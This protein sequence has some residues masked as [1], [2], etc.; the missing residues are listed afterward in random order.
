MHLTI[1]KH[2]RSG[3]NDPSQSSTELGL[4]QDGSVNFPITTGNPSTSTGKQYA[5]SLTL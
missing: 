4:T 5:Y 1:A 3:V 2:Q